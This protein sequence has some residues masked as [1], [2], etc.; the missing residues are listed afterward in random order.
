[1]TRWLWSCTMHDVQLWSS[2][3]LMLH[4]QV[5]SL[6]YDPVACKEMPLNY[7]CT[8]DSQTFFLGSYVSGL[9]LLKNIF[10]L[11]IHERHAERGR[12]VGRGR[13]RLHAG[14]PM[15]DSIP[16]LRDHALS[17]RQ[18]LNCWATQARPMSCSFS[19]RACQRLPILLLSLALWSPPWIHGAPQAMTCNIDQRLRP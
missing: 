13:N 3:H 18:T 4:G 7:E 17:Q 1:M 11:F 12:D 10:N 6:C 5:L 15:L 19:T 2:I 14:S 9:W 8:E 16:W